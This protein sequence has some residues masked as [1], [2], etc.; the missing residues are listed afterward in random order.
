MPK[1]TLSSH[2]AM[3][4]VYEGSEKFKPVSVEVIDEWRWGNVYEAIILEK[5]T[6]KYWSTDFR[7]QTGDNY[8]NDLDEVSETQ[9]VQ[10]EPYEKVIVE[11]RVVKD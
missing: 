4:A 3:E 9:F 2:E 7:V 8:Y 1:I 11:Y 5:D 6:G 10:V